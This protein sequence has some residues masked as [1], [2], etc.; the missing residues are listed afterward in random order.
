M[1]A[2]YRAS[3]GFQTAAFAKS[4]GLLTVDKEGK[5]SEMIKFPAAFF[6]V[7]VPRPAISF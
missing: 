3:H 5:I 6:K 2:H 4:V 7:K 1:L